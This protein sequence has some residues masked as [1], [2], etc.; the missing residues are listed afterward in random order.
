[1]GRCKVRILGFHN[2]DTTFLPSSDLPW[3]TVM[4]PTTSAAISEV[5]QTPRI[6]QGTWVIGF[7]RDGGI[8]QQPIII[9]TIPGIPIAKS[10]SIGDGFADPD[11]QYPKSD[12]LNE[13]DLSRLARNEHIES[14]IVQTKKDSIETGIDTALG[15]EDWDEP[16]TPSVCI[17]Q[18]PLT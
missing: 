18:S 15:L 5:G 13:S 11:G 4:Q 14:T 6:V 10:V 9:G 1:L 17:I 12:K 2:P 7:F 3:A 8:A 16:T